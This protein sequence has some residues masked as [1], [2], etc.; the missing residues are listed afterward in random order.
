MNKDEDEL[1]RR[2]ECN[3][4]IQNFVHIHITEDIACKIIR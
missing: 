2:K 4:L 3:N 1:K